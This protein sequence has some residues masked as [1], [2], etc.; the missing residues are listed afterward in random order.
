MMTWKGRSGGEDL[1]RRGSCASPLRSS[2]SESELPVATR[3][4][5]VWHG[6]TWVPA[7]VAT[8]TSFVEVRW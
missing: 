8:R 6:P 1:L 7:S 5:T 3:G 4:S 2:S